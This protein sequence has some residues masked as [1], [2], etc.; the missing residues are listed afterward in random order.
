MGCGASKASEEEFCN[1][2]S[3]NFK[4]RYKNI[5]FFISDIEATRSVQ[6]SPLLWDEDDEIIDH[7]IPAEV[8]SENPD[9]DRP[10]DSHLGGLFLI[11]FY[12]TKFQI[13]YVQIRIVLIQ[14]L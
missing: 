11:V 2:F 12:F 5:T 3:E 4:C 14:I 7:N 1:N 6:T 13:I 8:M 10:L 9:V